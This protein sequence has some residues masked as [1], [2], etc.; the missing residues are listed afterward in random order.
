MKG[1]LGACRTPAPISRQSI[2]AAAS[3]GP[4][5]ASDADSHKQWRRVSGGSLA[6]TGKVAGS[7]PPVPENNQSKVPLVRVCCPDEFDRTGHLRGTRS[8]SRGRPR[9]E[10]RGS[11]PDQGGQGAGRG[12]PRVTSSI[13]TTPS[14]AQHSTGSSSYARLR[15]RP[16][17][18]SCLG[19]W[20]PTGA[21]AP[22]RPVPAS[23]PPK[24]PSPHDP[25][26]MRG[27]RGPLA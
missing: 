4:R 22:P 20:R 13:H 1:K 27:K 9:F 25:P 15:H 24:A 21:S 16:A 14:T 11:H 8:V 19:P 26:V 5:H 17:T 7:A 6:A 10:H 23:K 3:T 2:Y 18:S 12:V